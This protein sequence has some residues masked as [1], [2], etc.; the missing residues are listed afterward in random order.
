M[1]LNRVPNWETRDRATAEFALANAGLPH[2]DW[3]ARYLVD[4][5]GADTPAR[6]LEVGCSYGPNLIALSELA[7]KWALSGIDISSANIEVG[8]ERLDAMGVDRPNVNLTTADA[9]RQLPYR[10]SSFDVVF[11]DA[12]LLYTNPLAARRAV[13]EMVRIASGR[14]V[15]L[16]LSKT[17]GRIPHRRSR[18]GWLHDYRSLF[19]GLPKVS[20][21]E[22]IRL[23]PTLRTAG[24]W[25]TLGMLTSVSLRQ[26]R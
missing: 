11:T 10:N 2:R 9:T 20:S 5:V 1:R 4:Q 14:V 16:E 18:D 25:P 3:L 6:V 23:P 22:T 13:R 24:R 8:C 12:V 7:P 21:V 15:T 17:N 26:T 19:D